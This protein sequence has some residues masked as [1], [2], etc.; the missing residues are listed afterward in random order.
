[1]DDFSSA[2]TNLIGLISDNLAY[3]TIRH[4]LY[5]QQTVPIGVGG[6]S[7]RPCVKRRIVIVFY[8]RASF[9]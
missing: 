5:I 2:R 7:V 9:T 8:V 3:T 1:L 6:C 4:A